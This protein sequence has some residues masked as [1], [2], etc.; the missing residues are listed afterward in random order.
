[1]CCSSYFEM[2]VLMRSR[3]LFLFGLTFFIF[4]VVQPIGNAFCT[5]NSD[6]MF[7]TL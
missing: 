3:D 4:N 1:M 6:E 5:F 7:A 2:K